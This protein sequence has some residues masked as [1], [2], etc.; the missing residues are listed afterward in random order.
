MEIHIGDGECLVVSV[1]TYSKVIADDTVVSYVIKD[2]EVILV[3][4]CGL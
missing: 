3:G 4:V 1:F 2:K